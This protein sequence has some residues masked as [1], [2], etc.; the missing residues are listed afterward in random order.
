M[1]IKYN[2]APDAPSVLRGDPSRLRQVLINLTGNALKFT[3]KGEVVIEVRKKAV[4]ADCRFDTI[5]SDAERSDN[6]LSHDEDSAK[7]LFSVRDTGIG[8]PAEKQA[9]IFESFTQA[10][11]STTR[12]YGGT[13]LGLTISMRLIKLMKGNIWVESEPGKGSTFYFTASFKACVDPTL[14]QENITRTELPCVKDGVDVLLAED[15]TFNQILAVR[16]LEKEGHKVFVVS[17]GIEAVSALKQQH[18]DLVLMDV[19]MPELDGLEATGLIRSSNLAPGVPIIAMTA[20]ALKE[21]RD[22]CLQAGMDDYISKPLIAGE[23][24]KALNKWLSRDISCRHVPLPADKS[25]IKIVSRSKALE[26]L[27]GDDRLLEIL[28]KSFIRDVPGNLEILGNAIGNKE[29]AIIKRQAHSIKSMA[30]SIGADPLN[31]VAFQLELSADNKDLESIS[32]LY[33]KL[34]VEAGMVLKEIEGQPA[35]K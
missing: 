10:D 14:L 21:D 33:E 13:G 34:K 27:S 32:M 2:I 23:F 7:L 1:S 15:N 9:K 35:N 25:D 20:N 19:Q 29:Y 31:D 12:K 24:Y 11:S 22:K 17:N 26:M 5:A 28:H 16:L 8:I 6:V 4:P 3:E 18:F 30:G